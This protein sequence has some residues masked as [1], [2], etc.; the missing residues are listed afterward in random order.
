MPSQSLILLR[1]ALAAALVCGMA[2]PQLLASIK[3]QSLDPARMEL[4]VSNAL[5]LEYYDE[6][7]ASDNL[8]KFARKVRERYTEG[9]LQRLLT[10]RDARTR[11]AALVALRLLGTMNSNQAMAQ[12]LHD[13]NL[14]VQK[15]AEEGLWSI[16]FRA[17]TPANNQELHRI[18]KL[19]VE[20]E[21]AQALAA[22]NAMIDK[23]PHFAEAY[24]Q[25]AIL[26]WRW[27]NYKN[28]IADCEQALK[29]NPYHFGAQSGMAQCYLQLKRPVEALKAFRQ[30][31]KINPNLQGV[32][33][34]IHQLEEML[35]ERRSRGDERK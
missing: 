2:G 10:H 6:L 12:C 14:V 4:Q 28:S 26:H 20:Q 23:T 34:S 35:R 13:D 1:V 30:A 19:I 15:A 21:Y 32:E 29:L 18:T 33:E 24:N 8:A 31:H 17:E 27:G 25:R 11:E 16:W 9:T 22:L 3:P 7:S 5:I